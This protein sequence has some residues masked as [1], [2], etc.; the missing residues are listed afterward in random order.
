MS[1]W[2]SV[3]GLRRGG[4]PQ[5]PHGTAFARTVLILSGS[6]PP[7]TRGGKASDHDASKDYYNW[8]A[9]TRLLASILD[10]YRATP[11]RWLTLFRQTATPANT[12]SSAVTPR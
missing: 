8:R 6:T 4:T 3:R 2:R 10:D 9:R 7:T 12:D 11:A 5:P 1:G